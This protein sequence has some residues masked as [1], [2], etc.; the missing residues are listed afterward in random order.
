MNNHRP[1]GTSRTRNRIQVSLRDFM[2]RQRVREA[3]RRAW[4][5]KH[6]RKVSL[7]EKAIQ[8]LIE[9]GFRAPEDRRAA[10]PWDNLDILTLNWTGKQK[11]G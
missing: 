8:W 11:L 10:E 2:K 1:W 7:D 5:D 4:A 3:T 9:K 6:Q